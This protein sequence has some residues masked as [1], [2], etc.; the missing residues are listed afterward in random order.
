MRKEQT[1]REVFNEA[2][3]KQAANKIRQLLS[4]IRNNPALSA[5]RWVWELIQNAKDAP[6]KY[7]KVSVEIELVSDHELRFKHNG[8]PFSINNISGLVRQVSSKSSVNEDEETTGKFGTGF[9]CTHLLSDVI[10]VKGILKYRG[11]RLFELVLDRSGRS[12]EE[13]MPRIRDVEEPF[14]EPEKHFN[15]IADYEENRKEDDYDTEFIY[16]LDSNEKYKAA[17]AG[18]DDLVNTLPITLVTQAKKIKQVHVIDR[19]RNTDVTYVCD[20]SCL[21]ENVFFSEIRINGKPKQYLSYITEEV[22]LTTEVIKTKNGYT[23]VKRDNK[24]P[25]LYRDFP[26]IG[27][28]K[29]FFPYTLNGFRLNPTEKRNC[30]PLNGEDNEEAKENR[31]IIDLAVDASLKF[32]EWLIA[33]NVTNRCLI[34]YSPKPKPEVDYDEDVALPWIN[35]LQS[36]WRAQLLEQQLVE[37][38]D[39]IHAMKEISVPSFSGGAS[40]EF[41]DLLDGFYIGRGYLPKKQY[42]EGWLKVLNADYK[43]WKA[44]LK[45][46]KDDFLKDLSDLGSVDALCQKLNKDEQTVLEWLN[47]VYAFLIKHKCQDDLEKYAIVPNEQGVF[48]CIDKLCSDQTSPIPSELKSIY[49]EVSDTAIE[50]ELVHVG[51]E[52]SAFDSNIDKFDLKDIIDWFNNGIESRKWSSEKKNTVV[53]ALISLM[54]QVADA[55]YTKRRKSMYRFS[56]AYREMDELQ[57][58]VVEDLHLWEKAD[59]YWFNNSYAGIEKAE[60]V[61]TMSEEFFLLGKTEEET[62]NWLNEYIAFYRD[63]S[64]GDL[65]KERSVFPDQL[66]LKLKPLDELR[67]D[68]GI[69]EAFKDL[70]NYACDKSLKWDIFRHQLLNSAIYGYAQHNPLKLGEVYEYVKNKFDEKNSDKETIAKQT[71][72][73]VLGSDDESSKQNRVYGFVKTAFGEDMPDKSLVETADGFKWEFANEYCLRMVCEKISK[74]VNLSGLRELSDELSD[75]SDSGLIEW[76]DELVEFLH[77]NKTYW[78]IISDEDDGIGIWL[79]QHNDFCRLQDLRIDGGIPEELK[80]L[81]E[82]NKHID[83]DLRADMYSLDAQCGK[84]VTDEISLKEVGEYI[85]RIIKEYVNEN[86]NKQEKDFVALVFGLKKILKSNPELKDVM[87]YFEKK[88]HSLYVWTLGEGETMDLVGEIIQ[89]GNDMLRLVKQILDGRSVKDLERVCDILDSAQKDGAIV[90][91]EPRPEITAVVPDPENN[92]ALTERHIAVSEV[93]YSGM[94]LEE[95]KGYVSEAKRQVVEYFKRLNEKKH[96]GLKFDEDR[97]AMDSYS[98]LY[99][100]YD[101]NGN[102]LPIVAHSYKGPQYRYFDLNP[103]DWD[104]LGKPG[105]MLWVVT[106]MKLK[107]IPMYALPIRRIQVS[108][109]DGMSK[110]ERAAMLTLMQAMKQYSPGNV[111]FD[112]GNCMPYQG[113]DDAVAFDYIPDELKECTKGI[114][115][116]CNEKLPALEDVFNNGKNIPLLTLAEDTSYAEA[117]KETGEETMREMFANTEASPETPTVGAGL[118]AIQ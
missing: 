39:G 69:P 41:F 15:K 87:K 36:N 4:A 50:D 81:C 8:D 26:L 68:D 97:I 110:R 77:S 47:K 11:Y 89:A 116:L 98:Q 43:V 102:E 91:P 100:I 67:Y 9:I 105:S 94:S 75:K 16:S 64:H 62:L 104:V 74:S 72:A 78:P 42:Q 20:S 60:K 6:N 46:E 45:Y 55:T 48:K 96:L 113:F 109:P 52:A 27:S 30:I 18:L 53:Y 88:K 51:V 21:D 32:N 25:I 85:D 95:I 112:F 7:G 71:I 38:E 107:C 22:A 13:L 56:S 33:H 23:L 83:W 61:S 84:Y 103:F 31:A 101:K 28:E 106:G 29:F 114:T 108:L 86:N 65:I 49:N 66:H 76:V 2:A 10:E 59:E 44:N 19:V 93:Q 57:T 117:I 40:A 24:Q 73:I 63:N 3:Y 118:D 17:V 111:R 14:Y 1:A 58:V 35:Q 115:M 80:D 82:N 79:N 70:A 90:S 99:G 5:K 37:S 12:S 54:P 92:G 34:A